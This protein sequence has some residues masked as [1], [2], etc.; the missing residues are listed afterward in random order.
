MLTCK[1]KYDEL[2][3]TIRGEQALSLNLKHM[4]AKRLLLGRLLEVASGYPPYSAGFPLRAADFRPIAS[5]ST[6]LGSGIS[7]LGVMPSVPVAQ[8][9]L[10]TP[11]L[12]I[13][14]LLREDAA[15]RAVTNLNVQTNLVQTQQNQ[16]ALSLLGMVRG[17]SAVESVSTSSLTKETP[18]SISNCPTANTNEIN[19]E[20]PSEKKVSSEETKDSHADDEL[21]MPRRPLTAYNIF[22]RCERAKLLGLSLDGFDFRGGT[23]DGKKARPHR[24]SHGKIPFADLAKHVANQWKTL[25]PKVKAQYDDMARRE[26]QAYRKEKKEYMQMRVLGK[27]PSF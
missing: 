16:A 21:A 20:Q 2:L 19:S 1:M 27:K 8:G 10:N 13:L 26:L 22:F 23:K 11:E 24:K 3:D 4:N 6:G 17:A 12:L 15:R 14:Q 5:Y 9:V 7:P 25:D 18:M